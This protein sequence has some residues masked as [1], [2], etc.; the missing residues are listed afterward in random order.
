MAS[1]TAVS[2]RILAALKT[3]RD[4]TA[5]QI[6][7]RFGIENV[8]ARISELRKSGYA[9]YLNTKRT[10]NG[11]V[12]RAYRL[13]TPTR[14]TIAAGLAFLSDPYMSWERQNMDLD[15]S[16]FNTRLTAAAKRDA[17]RA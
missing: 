8:S 4:L 7:S 5:N 2:A 9:V 10:Y 17:K 14:R 1:T 16:T 13:G 11:N 12:I 3:G 6:R 15:F